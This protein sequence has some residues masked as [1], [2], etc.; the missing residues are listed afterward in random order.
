MTRVVVVAYPAPVSAA[1][2]RSAAVGDVATGRPR[3]L[4][5][6]QDGVDAASREGAD[7]VVAADLAQLPHRGHGQIV[8]GVVELGPSCGGQPVPLGGTAPPV[9]LPR[10]RGVGLGVAA[11][12]Q[13]VEVPA[14]A[15]GGDAQPV[16]DLAGGRGALEQQLDDGAAGVSVGGQRDA[17]ARAASR[18]PR[19][20]CLRAEFHNTI[21]T[22][23]DKRGLARS[24]L[25]GP[26]VLRCIGWPAR[27]TVA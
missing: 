17:L 1:A 4:D 9:V 20:H 12:D 3:S 26:T 18:R 16:A 6:G 19:S 7:G 2:T 21:V 25:G 11:V 27:L 5:A 8:V 24:P 22:E 15:S 14:D 13:R 23:F 10:G